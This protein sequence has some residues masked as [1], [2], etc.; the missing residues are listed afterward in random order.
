MPAFKIAIAALALMTCLPAQTV[1]SWV[2]NVQ[3]VPPIA[4]ATPHSNLLQPS[5]RQYWTGRLTSPA[6]EGVHRPCSVPLL[7]APIRDDVNYTLRIKP[8]P[9]DMDTAIAAPP[10]APPCDEPSAPPRVSIHKR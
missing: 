1:P 6:V 3:L 4:G 7:R 9:K 5:P 2:P 8:A 10:P